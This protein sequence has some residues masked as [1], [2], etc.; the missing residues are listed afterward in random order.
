M[1]LTFR[2]TAG[3]HCGPF[4]GNF[5]ES[6][7]KKHFRMT[8]PS[9]QIKAKLKRKTAK[10]NRKSCAGFC[11]RL[12]LLIHYSPMFHFYTLRKLQKIIGFLTFARSIEMEH[13]AKMS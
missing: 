8:A 3:W 6:L 1:K 10:F 2:K 9:D 4:L 12:T 7:L 5:L 11:R 13:W